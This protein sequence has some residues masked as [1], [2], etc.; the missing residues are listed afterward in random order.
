MVRVFKNN[1]TGNYYGHFY[2]GSGKRIQF[3]CRTSNLRKAEKFATLKWQDFNKQ[4]KSQDEY[5][6]PLISAFCNLYLDRLSTHL[7]PRTIETYKDSFIQFLKWVPDIP[8]AEVSVTQCH[9][10]IFNH[11]PSTHTAVRHYK[12]LRRAFSLAVRW[13]LLENNPFLEIECP[14]PDQHRK[15]TLTEK[16]FYDLLEILPVK[17]FS[18]R[19][20]KRIIIVGRMTGLRLGELL[21][22]GID[23]VMVEKNILLVRNKGGF[24]TKSGRNRFVPLSKSTAKI[25]Q[26]QIEENRE[27][28]NLSVRGSSVLFPNLQGTFLSI[29]TVSPLFRNYVRQL[30]PEKQ[31]LCFHSLRGTFIT[32]AI[33]DGV[34]ISQVQLAA[35]HKTIRT[36]E[37]YIN[38]DLIKLSRLEESLNRVSLSLK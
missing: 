12:Q 18:E 15:D 32:Q 36:T 10:F 7:S 11:Q 3:S 27:H 17:T 5:T 16:E 14:K 33:E 37:G 31:N 29:F 19:R 38:Y 8:L 30:F 4:Q 22:V 2:N 1:R 25:I 21:H 24:R 34:P 9:D 23:D 26:E 20:F 35:G 28:P 6:S 13:K